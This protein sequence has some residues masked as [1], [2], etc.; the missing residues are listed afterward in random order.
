MRRI[1]VHLGEDA[2][3]THGTV[4]AT[5]RGMYLAPYAALPGGIDMGFSVSE[6]RFAAMTTDLASVALGD[7]ITRGT[8]QYSIV[9]VRPDDPSGLTVLHVRKAS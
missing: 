2:T 7:S 4:S 9:E 5:V 3:Y 8:T 6:P 1:L